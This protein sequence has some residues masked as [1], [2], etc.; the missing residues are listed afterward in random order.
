M[1]ER[2]N[3]GDL[4]EVSPGKIRKFQEEEATVVLRC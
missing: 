2:I 4:G 3:M 1:T